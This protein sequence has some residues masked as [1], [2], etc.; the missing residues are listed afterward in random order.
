[1]IT[2]WWISIALELAVLARILASRL[3]K[4]LPAFFGF[5]LF[6]IASDLLLA[7][8]W[9]NRYEYTVAWSIIEAFT[10][11]AQILLALELYLAYDR[12]YKPDPADKW[13]LVGCL[14]TSA[15]VGFIMLQFQPKADERITTILVLSYIWCT[16]VLWWT[17]AFIVL[18]GFMFHL[19][20]IKPA[21]NLTLHA[22][23]L[24]TYF[25]VQLGTQI[26]ADASVRY[27]V[28]ASFLRIAGGSACLLGWVVLL[29][30][31]GFERHK[32]N[33]LIAEAARVMS[34]RILRELSEPPRGEGFHTRGED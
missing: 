30:R 20:S 29:R 19:I 5:I 1:M 24:A 14:V 33:P 2:L 18:F 23:L 11:V 26:L 8:L 4:H 34:E 28:T 16:F 3:L 21:P 10:V 25:A 17:A 12:L 22:R 9:S 32:P 13:F 15:V 27:P 6:N 7:P 31:G